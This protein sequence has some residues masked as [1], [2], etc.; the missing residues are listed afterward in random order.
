MP[1][2]ITITPTEEFHE[3]DGAG[4]RVWSGVTASGVRCEV[5]VIGVLV[6]EG[7]DHTEFDTAG[8]FDD[9]ETVIVATPRDPERN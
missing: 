9:P 3:V 5:L 1:L 4:A 2:S 6:A 7:Q 8:C